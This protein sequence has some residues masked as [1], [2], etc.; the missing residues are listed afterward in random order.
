MVPS[1][2]IKL[3]SSLFLAG[4]LNIRKPD[5]E[6]KASLTLICDHFQFALPSQQISVL[7]R[8]SIYQVM[9]S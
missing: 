5:V 3:T 9:M 4:L 6:V 7:G 1:I 8:N 2:E